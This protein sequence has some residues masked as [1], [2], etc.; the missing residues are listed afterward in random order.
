MKK[1][2]VF[3]ALAISTLA[4]GV[5]YQQLDLSVGNKI[6]VYTSGLLVAPL[7]VLGTDAQVNASKISRALGASATINFAPQGATCTDSSAVTVLGA[8]AGDPCV[9]GVPLAVTNVD[10]GSL[11]TFSCFVSA[12]DAVKVRLC[13]QASEDV[14]SATFYVRV[15][16]AQ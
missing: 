15:I 1:R 13:S 10:G 9:V 12:A 7:S 11:S 3:L 2:L 14:A 5:V 4:F 8:R 6:R 16:S